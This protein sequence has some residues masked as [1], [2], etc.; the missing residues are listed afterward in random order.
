MTYELTPAG[1]KWAALSA[2]FLAR[3]FLASSRWARV[4]GLTYTPNVEPRIE[5]SDFPPPNRAAREFAI[6]AVSTVVAVPIGIA[7]EALLGALV[8][9]FVWQIV[10]V[11]SIVPAVVWSFL[12]LRRDDRFWIR[13][14]RERIGQA[15]LDASR[16]IPES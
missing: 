14:E 6:Y 9:L 3:W 7:T 16:D 5:L 11:A 8:P 10:F 4:H 12:G 13:L 2:P 15:A 1:A